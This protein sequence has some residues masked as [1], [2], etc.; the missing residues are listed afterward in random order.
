MTPRD[1]ARFPT[2]EAWLAAE[3]RG[4]LEETGI[5]E[6]SARHLVDRDKLSRY[7]AQRARI[8]KSRARPCLD[9]GTDF[10]PQSTTARRCSACA[11]RRRPGK[12][13]GKRAGDR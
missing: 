3:S 7:V 6:P 11:E 2:L 13:A 5:E 8:Q 4:E 9:C 12:N 10:Q 1:G